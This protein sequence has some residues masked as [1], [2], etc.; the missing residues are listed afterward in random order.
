M[1]CKRVT[2]LCGHYG[3]GKSNIAVN[4]AAELRREYEYVTLADLD[5]VNPYFRSADSRTELEEQGIRLIA[6]GY[7][8]SNL[9]V[10]ALPAEIYS[11]CADRESHVVIDLGGDD[12]GALALGRLRQFLL[13][14]DDF[15]MVFVLNGY[16]PLTRTPAEV[17]EVMQE[18]EAASGLPITAIV[19]NSNLGEETDA[20]TVLASL[21]L[22]EEVESLSGH[23][24]LFTSVREELFSN[25]RPQIDRLFPLKLQE[26]YYQ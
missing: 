18:V 13:Q 22:A 11:L 19:N 16:R 10:P 24:L 3:S 5:I 14:E 21:P 15:D 9:D 2:I 4:L 25:L 8:N 23:P 6:S 20:E 7:V 12:R 26:K 17:L 1:E